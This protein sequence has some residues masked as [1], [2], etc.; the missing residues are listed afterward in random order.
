M[1]K[2]KTNYNSNKQINEN[3]IAI[4]Q[5]HIPRTHHK[6]TIIREVTGNQNKHKINN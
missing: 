4:S 5:A 2:D 1:H 3:N 6:L